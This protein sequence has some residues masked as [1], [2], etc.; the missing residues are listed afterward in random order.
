MVLNRGWQTFARARGLGGRCTLHFKYDG[1]GT[2]YMRVFRGDDQRVVYFPEDSSDN[3]GGEGELG[4]SDARPSFHDGSS[5]S[6]E[7][8]SSGGYDQPPRR[9]ARVE[10]VGGSSR[11][12][13]LVKLERSPV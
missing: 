7:S 13:A 8:S 9:R 6:D 10:D 11:R 12:I 2:L 4:L 1:L 3:D 5:S